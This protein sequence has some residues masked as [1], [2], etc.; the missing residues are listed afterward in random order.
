M[1][2]SAAV[3][4][5]ALLG[6]C[7]EM[8][9]ADFTDQSQRLEGA[10]LARVYAVI[11]QVYREDAKFRTDYDPVDA[12]FDAATLA[13]NF[14]V[15]AQQSETQTIDDTVIIQGNSI[16]ITRWEKPIRL[17]TTGETLED[18]QHLEALSNRIE[19][20]TPL[21]VELTT[22]AEDANVFVLIADADERRDLVDA[23]DAFSRDRASPLVK[24][25]PDLP[26]YPCIARV[27]IDP[28]DNTLQ[29]AMIFLKSELSGDFRASCLTEEF[30]Q[31][32]GLFNDGPEIRP[33]IFN[34]DAEFIELTRHD[35]YLLRIL[36]DRRLRAGMSQT[37]AEPIVRV[38]AAELLADAGT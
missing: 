32:L 21:S 25:W 16:P 8:P 19:R 13:A 33:S 28:N 24:A 37:E 7:A 38:I 3:V 29:T 14:A 11:E 2:R 4:G 18:I 23:I 6:G 15:V 36:Y 5:L 1:I 27:L 31:A 34:D 17:W 9:S 10:K 35:E 20:L 22:Q 26:E 30:V 12:P